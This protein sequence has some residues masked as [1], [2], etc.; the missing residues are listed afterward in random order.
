MTVQVS[1]LEAAG[2]VEMVFSGHSDQDE[3]YDAVAR[4][5]EEAAEHLTARFLVDLRRQP[6]GGKALDIFALGEYLSGIP[7]GVIER[8]AL[9][10]P[11][12]AMVVEELEFFET[13]C[14][15]RGLD[16]RAFQGRAD[17]LAWLTA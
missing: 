13:V 14:R 17:A 7:R 10:L 5:G 4:A 8:E 6:P 16:V 11:D 9:V 1:Y 12:D 15:N 2:V 3:L